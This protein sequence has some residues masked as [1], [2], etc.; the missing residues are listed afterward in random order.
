M[1]DR[2]VDLGEFTLKSGQVILSDPLYSLED[3]EGII[4]P[5]VETG[6]WRGFVL[7]NRL[8]ISSVNEEIHAYKDSLV[9]DDKP[10]TD[11]SWEVLP[12]DIAVDS[13][14]AGI[15]DTQAFQNDNYVKTKPEIDTGTLFY[16]MCCDIT[17]EPPGAGIVEGGVVSSTGL[18]DGRYQAF[19]SKNK[20][21]K[22]VAIKIVFEE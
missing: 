1:L 20:D 15:F 12:G 5:A 3:E 9:V 13:G 6:L 4:I 19:V 18:G 8:E 17:Y 21:G 16:G 2:L 22:I 7:K 14:Q 11:L 10:K